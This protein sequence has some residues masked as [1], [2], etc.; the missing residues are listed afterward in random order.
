MTLD[1]DS[2]DN[3]FVNYL[4]RVHRDHD[5]ELILSGFTRLLNNPL[6]SSYLPTK[7]VYMIITVCIF[8]E[9]LN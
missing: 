1:H 6:Q 5:L 8:F 9:V 7:K 2:G 4:S 3:L